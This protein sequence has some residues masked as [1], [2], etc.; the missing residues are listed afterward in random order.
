MRCEDEYCIYNEAYVCILNEIAINASGMCEECTIVSLPDDELIS[1]KRE[2]L[3]R[4]LFRQ[5]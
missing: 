5:N 2:H 1:R 3:A 4:L